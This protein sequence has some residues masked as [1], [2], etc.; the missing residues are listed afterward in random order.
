MEIKKRLTFFTI[1]F[2]QRIDYLK[3]EGYKVKKRSENVQT[4]VPG[5]T[6]KQFPDLF[7]S[8]FKKIK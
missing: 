3:R 7:S 2:S 1:T 8:L 5:G 4:L 6:G